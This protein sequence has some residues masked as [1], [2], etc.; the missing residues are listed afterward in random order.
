MSIKYP[1]A[2]AM[3]MCIGYFTHFYYFKIQLNT[4]KTSFAT[5]NIFNQEKILPAIY[6]IEQYLPLLQNKKVGLAVNHTSSLDNTHLIDTLKSIGI[7]IKAIFVPE[8]G[9]R[10]K[11]DAGENINSSIDKKTNIPI[12]S[13]YGKNKKPSKE[14]LENID[15]IVF[16][17]Q[18]VGVRFYTYIST[19]HYLMESCAENQK[20]LVILDRPN[21]NGS[22]VDG[23]I[24]DEKTS[25]F[26]AMHPIPV[27]HG[28]TIG[29][30][31]QMINGEKWLKNNLQAHITIIKIKNYMHQKKYALP[32][33]PS[34]NLPN[35]ASIALYASLCLFEGTN[36]SVGRGTF[37]P[38]QVWGGLDKNLGNFTFIPKSIEGMSKKPIHEN[39]ICYGENLQN[40]EPKNE[41]TLVYLLKAYQ[42]TTDKTKFFN[43][44]F[45]TLA[46]TDILRKQIEAGWNEKQIRKTWQNSLNKY[47]KIR[48]KY[49]LY[50]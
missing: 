12:I 4:N 13:L 41:F 1:I 7:D 22:Y 18:D 35:D 47:K 10:G 31:A 48:K 3:L 26:V 2:L 5:K 11:A 42:K 36:I 29:E 14:H 8:H 34:P 20:K 33:K 49:I 21:P 28:L 46:G 38:F 37:F 15:V 45:N 6:Q 27:V 17:M 9:L 19:L 39:Q 40:I 24:K 32:I 16:D 25:S 30:L 43:P 44:F 50:E 23:W